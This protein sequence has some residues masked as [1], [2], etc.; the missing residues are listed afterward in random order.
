[1]HSTEQNEYNTYHKTNILGRINTPCSKTNMIH[2]EG[3]V[4][5]M[6]NTCTK[7]NKTYTKVYMKF[8]KMNM[9]LNEKNIASTELNITCITKYDF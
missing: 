8:A 5:D 2:S 3:M 7:L 9:A 1:M 6:T 4:N